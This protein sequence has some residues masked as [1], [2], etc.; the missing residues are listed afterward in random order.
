[1]D[2]YVSSI[3]RAFQ[4]LLCYSTELHSKIPLPVGNMMFQWEIGGLK[5][6]KQ[7]FCAI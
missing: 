1:M 2:C 7:V 4:C 5:D 6:V 3:S